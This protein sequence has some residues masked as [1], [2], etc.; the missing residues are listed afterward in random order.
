MI[1]QCLAPLVSGRPNEISRHSQRN[2]ECAPGRNSTLSLFA[3]LVS[4]HPFLSLAARDEPAKRARL[5]V[6]AR[7]L[8]KQPP[9]KHELPGELRSP[10]CW[11]L[12]C[13]CPLVPF[14]QCDHLI[15][16]RHTAQPAAR[17]STRSKCFELGKQ[18]AACAQALVADA[19][20]RRGGRNCAAQMSS[21]AAQQHAI[22]YISRACSRKTYA[23]IN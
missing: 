6:S 19:C 21:S 17:D 16:M 11:S 1:W 15:S 18:Q 5:V 22:N 23:K 14:E 7:P 4:L 20:T 10:D 12:T 8:P 2:S 3:G 9:L 13:V